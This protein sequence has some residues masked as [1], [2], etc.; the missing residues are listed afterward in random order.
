MPDLITLAEAKSHLNIEGDADDA[1]LTTFITVSSDLVE[2]AA[3]RVWRTTSYTE[4]H[5]GGTRDLVLLHSPVSSITSITDQGGTVDAAEYRLHAST[6]LIHRLAQPFIGGR[7]EVVVTY[8]AGGTTPALIKHGTK[9]VLRHLWKT[10]RGTL[11]GRKPLDGDAPSAS[12]SL[13]NRVL[14]EIE[15]HTFSGGIG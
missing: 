7:E 4:Y 14:E 2:E 1:E 9:E 10:Q 13:P 11:G 6:G 5:D 15:P 8:V 3:N 12:F